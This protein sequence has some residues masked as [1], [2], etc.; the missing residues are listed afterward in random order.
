MLDAFEHQRDTGHYTCFQGL[1]IY[2][3][4]VWQARG[5]YNF[6]EILYM[7][8]EKTHSEKRNIFGGQNKRAKYSCSHVFLHKIKID[9]F[10]YIISTS[11]CMFSRVIPM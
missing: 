10:V 11:N 7:L 4:K 3:K 6:I 1:I 2:M 8:K 5:M 9:I